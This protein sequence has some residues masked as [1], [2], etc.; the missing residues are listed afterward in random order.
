MPSKYPT[1][2][3]PPTPAQPTEIFGQWV[4]VGQ[5]FQAKAPFEQGVFIEQDCGHFCSPENKISNVLH[6]KGMTKFGDLGWI[7]VLPCPWP[8]ALAWAWIRLGL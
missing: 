6:E 5:H 3:P 4:V 1:P 7:W 2:S 8:W